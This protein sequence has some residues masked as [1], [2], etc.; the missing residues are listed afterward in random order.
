MNKTILI[1]ALGCL[2]FAPL[3]GDNNSYHY[4]GEILI[5][6]ETW[7][8]YLALDPQSHRL[9]VSQHSRYDVVDIDKEK[10]VGAITDTPG[11]HGFALATDLKRGFTS[12]GL[13]AK[14][15]IVDLDS[16]KTLS[17][18]ST[19][20]K[21]DSIVYDPKNKEVY[22]FNGKGHNS[23]VYK[24]DTGEVVATI[25]LPG[26]PEFSQV[27]PE[28]GQIYVNIEDQNEVAVIDTHTHQIVNTWPVAPGDAPSSMAIDLINH[29][30]F[31]GCDNK[32]CVIL[33][34]QS[35]KLVFTLPIGN[36]V[37]STVF[38]PGTGLIFNACGKD[39]IC[40]IL[41]E[42]DPDHYSTAQT[43]PT[44]DGARTMAVDPAT[45]KIYFAAAKSDKSSASS[46]DTF[47]VLIY[48]P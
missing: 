41:H 16:L 15:S 48:S 10:V 37:D 23:T 20:E 25:P 18:V 43:L 19:G 46:G 24:A 42:D 30:L 6:G 4:T 47:R 8:D 21:P 2:A 39:G 13:E 33:N 35:G 26:K 31:I 14:S 29:R 9:Y 3:H 7:W 5:G 28:A 11:C 36:G 27:D 38:D 22:T 40:V 1:V 17:K 44:A 32:T 34:S 45:H 12:N